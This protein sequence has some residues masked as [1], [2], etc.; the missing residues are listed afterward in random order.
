[1]KLENLDVL[2]INV[3]QLQL[4]LMTKNLSRVV[5]LIFDHYWVKW[6]KTLSVFNE[7]SIYETNS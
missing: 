4:H 7:S 5:R 2:C 1:M 6:A 3:R